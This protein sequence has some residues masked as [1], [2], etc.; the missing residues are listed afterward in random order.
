MLF[1]SPRNSQ[2]AQINLFDKTDCHI[3]VFPKSHHAVVQ[4]WLEERDML[5]IE[6]DS[7]DVWF[8]TEE[9]P[10]F[11]YNKTYEEA[12][13]DPVVVLHTSG[14]TG[15]PKPVVARVGMIATSDAAHNL[16]EFH[17]TQFLM[18]AWAEKAKRHFVPSMLSPF[19]RYCYSPLAD[20][21]PCSAPVPCRWAIQLLTDGL[22]LAES[23]H[24]WD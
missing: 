12:E 6:V 3:V 15:L 4:P 8:P 16:P 17:G 19:V 21:C 24:P 7:I 13:N 22:L 20:D 2:E 9:V 1:V 14:S 5:A 11:P 10:H 23:H 18:R